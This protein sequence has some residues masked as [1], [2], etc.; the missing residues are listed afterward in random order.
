MSQAADFWLSSGFRLLERTDAGRLR[1]TPDFFAAYWQRPELRPVAESCAAERALHAALTAE[2]LR[3]VAE[4][5]LAALDEPDAVDNYRAVLRFRD[6]L[7]AHDTL[8]AA[9]LS[10]A[11]G[12]GIDFPPLFVDHLAHVVLRAALDGT[13]DPFR[14][15]AGELFFRRQRVTIADGR[16]VLADRETVDMRSRAGGPPTAGGAPTAGSAPAAGGT[17]AAGAAPTRVEID[18]LSELSGGFYW[19]RSDAFDIAIDIAYPQPGLDGLA[20]AMEAWIRHL[21]GVDAGITPVS[22]IE[23]ER[24]VWHIGLDR[25]AS[26]ILDALYRGEAPGEQRLR[27]ILALFRM[28]IR[29]RAAVLDRVAGRPVYLALA[30]APDETVHMKPQNLVAN[31]PLKAT[32]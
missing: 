20:R 9:Y 8:E 22:R 30:M 25:D 4:A 21:T 18:V 6:F 23:D 16:I 7:L 10:V 19:S 17:L 15:R 2:P 12:R 3:P 32:S 29:D 14:L 26:A 5:E 28:E 1:A 13:P 24:W 31:L 11:T 27:Q